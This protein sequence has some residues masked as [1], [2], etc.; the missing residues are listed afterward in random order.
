MKPSKWREKL[1]PETTTGA[2]VVAPSQ[3]Q[4]NIG[5]WTS[6][7]LLVVF[8]TNNEFSLTWPTFMERKHVEFNGDFNHKIEQQS[9]EVLHFFANDLQPLYSS[10]A[11]LQAFIYYSHSIKLWCADFNFDLLTSAMTSWK[12]MRALPLWSCLPLGVTTWLIIPT[13]KLAKIGLWSLVFTSSTHPVKTFRNS[14]QKSKLQAF[15]NISMPQTQFFK[16]L[17]MLNPV[18]KKPIILSFSANYE[19]TNK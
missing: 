4:V 18:L 11:G 10:V 14:H 8:L 7:Q 6:L 5:E 15:L 19:I 16:A 13:S 3:P 9:A 17:K 1:S 2:Q 12:T